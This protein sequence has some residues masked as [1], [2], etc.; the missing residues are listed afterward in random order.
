MTTHDLYPKHNRPRL[1][2]PAL[3]RLT[4][5]GQGGCMRI[6]QE[7]GTAATMVARVQ[8][9]TAASKV[10]TGAMI[11]ANLRH[12]QSLVTADNG[13]VVVAA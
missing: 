3:K 6:C 1:E 12:W 9:M 13:K 4:L 8:Q 2:L 5:P 10:M 7:A 11:R